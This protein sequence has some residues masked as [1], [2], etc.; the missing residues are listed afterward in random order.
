[1]LTKTTNKSCQQRQH[2]NRLLY[3]SHRIIGLITVVPVILWTLSGMMHPF[4]A[5]WFRP[6]LARSFVPPAP[7][8]DHLP[9][10][11]VQAVLRQHGLGSIRNFRLVTMDGTPYYQI[12]D[13]RNRLRYFHG[14]TGAVLPDGDRVYAE[15]L[16]RYF[17]DDQTSSV[18]LERQEAFSAQYRE[19]NRLLPVYRV[20]FARRDALDIY[21]ETEHS[22][23]GTFN[24]RARKAFL[25]VFG[26]FHNWTFLE[27]I[28][29]TPLR[30]TVQ[31]LLLGVILLAALSGL[32]VY[33]WFWKRFSTLKK[34]NTSHARLRK[35]HRQVGLAV[36]L[37][38]FTF[39][40]SGAFHAFTKYEPDDRLRYVQNALFATDELSYPTHQLPWQRTRAHG[41]SVVRMPQGA[42]FQLFGQDDRAQPRTYYFDAQ[43]GQELPDGDLIYGRYLANKFKAHRANTEAG[44]SLSGSLPPDTVPDGTELARAGIVSTEL[45]TG[46]DGEYGFINKR[47]PVIRVAYDWPEPVRYFVE[48]ASSRLSVRVEPLNV[49]EGYSFGTL[50][51]FH[52]VG[53]WLN[54]DIRDGLLVLLALGILSVS[55]L[56]LFVYLKL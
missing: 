11:S 27:V 18:T 37:V 50:H 2:R 17:A 12:K 3:R 44:V 55:L 45:V 54:K 41:A 25:W 15:Y 30:V 23:L 35:Y 33:G 9:R 49:I 6:E 26:N 38:T 34:P 5:N 1:M 19:I 14:H 8:G 21:V 39:A 47:L 43:S 29:S 51:K 16:A 40:L 46:F 31:L 36:S 13:R 28:T 7:V 56:G 52:F 48:T 42:F 32:V 20:A 24:T 22:R 4:M 53:D 10:Q